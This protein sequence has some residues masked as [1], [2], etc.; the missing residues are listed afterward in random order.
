MAANNIA[1]NERIYYENAGGEKIHTFNLNR[2]KFYLAHNQKIKIKSL[3]SQ[4]CVAITC[5]VTI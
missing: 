4:L 1:T 2:Q 5:F 3:F